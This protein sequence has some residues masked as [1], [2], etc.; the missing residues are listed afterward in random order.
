MGFI[1]DAWNGIT[2]KTQANAAT[3]GGQNQIDMSM[4]NAEL[5]QNAMGQVRQDQLP[6]LQ[7]GQNAVGGLNDYLNNPTKSFK[8]QYSGKLQSGIGNLNTQ[9]NVQAGGINASQVGNFG[10]TVAPTVSANRFDDTTRDNIQSNYDNG[11][12]TG[13]LSLDDFQADPSYEFRKQ[14]GMDGIQGSAAAGGSL[15]SGA[16][17]KSLNQHNSGLASQE[18]SNA[19]QRDQSQKQQQFGV[20]TGLRGQDHNIFV[21]DANRQFAS[22]T[23]NAAMSQ[24]TDQFNSNMNYNSSLNNANL[25]QQ[26]NMFNTNSMQNAQ[27]LNQNHG[28]NALGTIMGARGQDYG[29]YDGE[30]SKRFN[31][32]F[33][34]S[35]L[36]QNSASDLGRLGLTAAGMQADAYMGASNAY[37]NALTGAANARADG[38]GNI[39]GLG[40][41]ALGWG[42]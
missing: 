4:S 21:D 17:L 34:V 37:A 39:L 6:W 42:K 15:L 24:N 31:Q 18:Y 1:K 11:K 9:G 19:W 30:D 20:D 13:G 8:D 33:G 5:I 10:N 14:Q 12:Y 25:Q 22:D 23:T 29:I 36:G 35:Q 7:A 41:S 40:A 16:A 26:A 2:G 27:S 28:L 3:Q 38:W 32:L